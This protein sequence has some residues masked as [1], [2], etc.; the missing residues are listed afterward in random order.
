VSHNPF[1]AVS[2]YPGATPFAQAIVFKVLEDR[3][4]AIPEG[5]HQRVR[6][7]TDLDRLGSIYL[8]SALCEDFQ[9]FLAQTNLAI[10]L[11]ET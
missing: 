5:L 3:F 4:G 8:V 1:Q 9:A 10:S 2:G 6:S 7:I 11:P